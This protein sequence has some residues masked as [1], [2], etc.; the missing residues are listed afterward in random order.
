MELVGTSDSRVGVTG[1]SNSGIGV[2]GTS[3][4]QEAGVQGVGLNVGVEGRAD[5]I[6][7]SGTASNIGVKGFSELSIGVAGNSTSGYGGTFGGG[8]APLKLWPSNTQGPP[9][10]GNHS[11]GELYVDNQGVLYFCVADGTRLHPAGTWK[12]VQFV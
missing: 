1:T 9:T 2:K 7:V 12:K 5:N 6:G 3:S 8:R 11:M 4:Q 10:S